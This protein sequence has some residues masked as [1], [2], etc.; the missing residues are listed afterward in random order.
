MPIGL[1][2]TTGNSSFFNNLL[3]GECVPA[4]YLPSLL[5]MRVTR[6]QLGLSKSYT[7]RISTRS[8]YILSSRTYRI[9]H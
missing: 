2:D 3:S 7:I 9:C 6:L 1:M 4:S 8:F 5:T